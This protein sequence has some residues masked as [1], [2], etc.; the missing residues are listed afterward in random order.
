MIAKEAPDRHFDL[1]PERTRIVGTRNRTLHSKKKPQ[2]RSDI[3]SVDLAR[4]SA[5]ED[6]I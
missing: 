5:S 6:M 1:V 4:A 2:I 3:G